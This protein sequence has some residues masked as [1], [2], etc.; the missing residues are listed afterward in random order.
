M[1]G[2]DWTTSWACVQHALDSRAVVGDAS[3]AGHWV[4]QRLPLS[5]FSK[6][7]RLLVSN[8]YGERPL[9]LRALRV[10]FVAAR[11]ADG[12]AAMPT[13]SWPAAPGTTA[14]FGGQG[15]AFVPPGRIL[16][17]DTLLVDPDPTLPLTEQELEV[18]LVLG[19]E[20][21][22]C[23]TAACAGHAA[24]DRLAA[25]TNANGVPTLVA[26]SPALGSLEEPTLFIH[27]LDVDAAA[28]LRVVALIGESVPSTPTTGARRE[29]NGPS[30][31]IPRLLAADT[32]YPF[33][34]DQSLPGNR[35]LRPDRVPSVIARFQ[36]DALALSGVTDVVVHA[37][38]SDLLTADDSR[39]DGY[40]W[41]N[42]STL[43]GAFRRLCLLARASGKRIHATTLPVP[44]SERLTRGAE[45]TRRTLNAWFRH[46]HTFDSCIELAAAQPATSANVAQRS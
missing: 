27:R 6:R 2:T 21:P 19:S 18:L 28:A 30:W 15:V 41:P 4:I 24:F 9:E 25:T 43:I 44:T 45:E 39:A 34:F 10:R 46:S 22:R 31:L 32:A 42:V 11:R 33:V 38:L 8:E 3:L 5:V 35:L 36:R 37:G 40:A 12:H 16:V 1:L 7:L 29:S 13:A 20:V 17:S 14:T 26:R 23:L